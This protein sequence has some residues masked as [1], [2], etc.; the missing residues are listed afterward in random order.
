MKIDD[1]VVEYLNRALTNELTAINQYWLHYRVLHNWGLNKLADFE[2]HESIDEMKHADLLADRIL[3]LEGLPNFQAIHKLKVGETVEEI[4]KADLALELEAIPLLKDAIQHCETVRDYVSR[5]V[6]ERILESEE[7]HVDFLETQFELI[8]RM[9]LQNYVQ[10][11][12]EAA[13]AD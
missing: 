3:F 10:L 7:E 13:E 6:F 2:R 5:E 4:L 11:Q 1:K 9:G 12:S 8:Q